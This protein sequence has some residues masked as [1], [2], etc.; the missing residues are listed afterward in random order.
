MKKLSL[1]LVVLLTLSFASCGTNDTYDEDKTT[2]TTTTTTIKTT[3]YTS[4]YDYEDDED[5]FLDE[6]DEDYFLDEDDDE[7][8]ETEK[9][10]SYTVYITDS[11][12]KYHR[13]SCGYLKK[14]CYAIDI[15]KAEYE[16][17]TPCSRCNP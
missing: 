1:L 17:Y 8:E 13:K 12:S 15:D 14:S 5:N 7:E 3:K 2:T 9:K 6:D 4:S 11:G 16:G 10:N